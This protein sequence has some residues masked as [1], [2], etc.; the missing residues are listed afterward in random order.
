MREDYSLTYVSGL[1][2]PNMATNALQT[3]N[4][5]AALAC[6]INPATLFVRNL[7]PSRAQIKTYYGVSVVAAHLVVGDAS[8]APLARAVSPVQCA[9][10]PAAPSAS[11]LA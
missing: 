7:A 4:M 9:D 11:R 2:Y 5:A 6:Y 8:L 10:R 3:I 1:S